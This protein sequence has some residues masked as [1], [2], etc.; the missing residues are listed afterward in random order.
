MLNCQGVNVWHYFSLQNWQQ[1]LIETG[2]ERQEE[3]ASETDFCNKES[4]RSTSSD[5]ASEVTFLN[6]TKMY[7]SEL[8]IIIHSYLLVP[9]DC[10]TEPI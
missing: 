6:P 9:T 3:S 4:D 8:F 2:T 5:L 10:F 7:S 1:Q